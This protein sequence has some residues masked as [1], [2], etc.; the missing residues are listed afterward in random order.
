MSANQKTIHPSLGQLEAWAHDELDT[1]DRARLDQHLS[2][3]VFCREIAEDLRDFGQA[4]AVAGDPD[5]DDDED[6]VAR[7]L[8]QL[9]GRI[10]AE[11]LVA[12]QEQRGEG[13]RERAVVLP[14]EQK[15]AGAPPPRA[16]GLRSGYTR[17]LAV[18]ASLLIATGFAIALNRQQEV[19]RLTEELATTRLQAEEQRQLASRPLAN[20]AIVVAA[21]IDDPLRGSS[22]GPASLAGGVTVVVSST[23]EVFPPG[24]WRVIVSDSDGQ[25][26][27]EIDGL[28]PIDG[29]LRFLLLPGSLP[30]GQHRLRLYH[31]SELWPRVFALDLG[32]G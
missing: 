19:R 21:P 30:A 22:P 13:G 10:L 5:Q 4:D 23:T 12:A 7:A 28:A 18:A 8:G 1:A 31:G 2:G 3:C 20:P 9:R 29:Q 17:G 6:E 32:H 25:V 24:T 16:W 11:D 15:A 26:E 14:F 27:L